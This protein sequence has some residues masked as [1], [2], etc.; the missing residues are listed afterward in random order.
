MASGSD[1]APN[2]YRF[3]LITRRVTR[4]MTAASEQ[5]RPTVAPD[6]TL[7]FIAG[8]VGQ[9]DIYRLMPGKMNPEKFFG[10]L[11]DEWDPSVSPDGRWVAFSS[12][13]EGTW[14][15][16]I[17]HSGAPSSPIRL[18]SWQGEEWDPSFHPSGRMLVFAASSGSAPSIF[19]LCLYGETG[20]T[21]AK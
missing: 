4:I 13:R 16:N 7:Y 18:T 5:W 1:K 11:S 6:G 15:V 12:N 10:S 19:G 8:S 9:F 20:R 2:L 21:R 14:D 3:D 17:T